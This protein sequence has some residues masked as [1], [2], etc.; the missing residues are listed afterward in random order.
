MQHREAHG[1][2][3]IYNCYRRE[4]DGNRTARKRMPGGLSNKLGPELHPLAWAAPHDF[5]WAFAFR[6]T[7]Q[8]ALRFHVQS[9]PK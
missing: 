3:S 2:T 6:R 7:W 1:G 9:E 4:T 5:S 8:R